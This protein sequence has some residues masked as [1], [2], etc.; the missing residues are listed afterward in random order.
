MKI[1]KITIISILISLGAQ[2]GTR[3]SG[4]GDAIALDF[5]ATAVNIGSWLDGNSSDVPG[6]DAAHFKNKLANLNLSTTDK[7]LL[8]DGIEKDAVNYPAQVKIIVNRARWSKIASKYQ[9]TSLVL[10]EFLGIMGIND[11]LYSVSAKIGAKIIGDKEDLKQFFLCISTMQIFDS[12]ENK[13]V[14]SDQQSGVIEFQPIAG[15]T[16]VHFQHSFA[17]EKYRLQG[18]IPWESFGANDP[19]HA[20]IE[21]MMLDHTGL[22]ANVKIFNPILPTQIGVSFGRSPRIGLPAG[23]YADLMMFCTKQ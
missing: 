13:I 7:V 19:G 17:G 5:I 9:K 8:I 2:A 6:L 22:S 20:S 3:D 11:T 16:S 4:G 21:Y 15:G 12:S 14:F 10:H 23:K 1:L 18:S